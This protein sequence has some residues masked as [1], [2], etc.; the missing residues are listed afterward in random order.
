[1]EWAAAAAAAHQLQSC[2]STQSCSNLM[3]SNV[4]ASSLVAGEQS[5]EGFSVPHCERACVSLSER[6]T[7]RKSNSSLGEDA[8]STLAPTH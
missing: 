3:K 4:E 5:W 1:M 2:L 6:G 7:E 8:G